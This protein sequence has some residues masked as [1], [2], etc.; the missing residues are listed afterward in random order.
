MSARR[1]RRPRH[2]PC[3]GG[4]GRRAARA[5]ERQRRS[6][7]RLL[8]GSSDGSRQDRTAR[9]AAV[10]SRSACRGPGPDRGR[11][12]TA[13]SRV[14][15]MSILGNRVTRSED[16]RFITGRATF[17]DDIDLPGAVHVTFVRSILPHA[18]IAA[19]D[20]SGVSAIPGAQAFT[21]ADVDLPPLPQSAPGL[22]ERMVRTV[23]ASDVV[24]YAGEIVAVVVTED[25]LQ[26]PDAAELVEVDLDELETVPD[27]RTALEGRALLFPDIGTNVCGEF[28]VEDPDPG[29]FA[30]CEVVVRTTFHSQRLASCP[31][32]CRVAAAAWGEDGRL[33]HWAS[34]QTPHGTR[35]AL[36]QALGVD[37]GQVR[38]RVPDVG[39]GFGPKGSA[40]VEDMLV[41]WVARRLGR[42]ARWAETRTENMLAL[43]HGRAQHQELTLGGSRDGALQAYRM[44]IVQDSGAY[45]DIGAILP[46][47]TRMCASG[48]YT[49]PKI[50]VEARSVVTNTTPVT[51]YR[52]AGRPEATQAIERAIDVFALEAELD[53]ADVRRRNL[54][55]ADAF[56]YR[57]AT[58]VEYDSGDYGRALALALERAGYEELRAEQR[59]RRQADGGGPRLGIGLSAYIEI[60]NGFAEPEWGAVEITAQGGAT[61]RTG[62]GP[63]GQGHQ[64]ALAMLVA[65]RLGLPFDAITVQ[66][67][68]TDVIPRGTG[69]YGSRSLQSG[70][71]AVDGAAVRMVD[72]AKELAADELEASPADLWLDRD[73]GGFHVAR[74]PGRPRPWAQLAP[75]LPG[76][77]RP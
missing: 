67:G 17:G 37:P 1:A 75:R 26:G 22:D 40:S 51:A 27:V 77:G 68:D 30:G 18:R 53:P 3:A 7:R 64:T 57:T 6:T 44:Q 8:P 23:M 41:A 43:G 61:V 42:P 16:R 49:I 46:M 48:P 13:R 72:R 35:D 31:M 2:R 65:D 39:G 25:R 12:R 63:T 11:P 66:H 50:E 14:E 4:R 24:R 59:R 5:G 36:A 19:I 20:T 69:S 47:L 55:P 73:R 29:L 56:P 45:P 9:R 58:G 60:T 74:G 32:E 15:G 33:T 70:G 21:A 10:G 34:T 62:L 71:V 76:P 28:P 38:V 54:I 52:G